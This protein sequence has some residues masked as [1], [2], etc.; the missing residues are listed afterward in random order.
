MTLVRSQVLVTTVGC[1]TREN[2]LVSGKVLHPSER[3]CFHLN[4]TAAK[5]VEK[6]LSEVIHASGRS[7]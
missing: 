2:E 1:L 4:T 6:G 7:F 3:W 5:R